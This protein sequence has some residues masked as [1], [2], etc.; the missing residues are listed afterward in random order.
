MA[1][2][3]TKNAK[4]QK[5]VEPFLT[6]NADCSLRNQIRLREDALRDYNSSMSAVGARERARGHKEGRKEGIKK[7]STAKEKEMVEQMRKNGA[8][9][10][11]IRAVVGDNY[12]KYVVSPVVGPTKAKYLDDYVAALDV[13]YLEE[14]YV[15]H[16]IS[17][18]R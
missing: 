3:T 16:K 2:K 1:R 15:P 10:D 13:A 7:G 11:F 9:E 5:D 17:G 14:P 8:S 4:V 18:A 6:V 12:K